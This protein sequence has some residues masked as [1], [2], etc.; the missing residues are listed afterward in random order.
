[1]VRINVYYETD[2]DTM[3]VILP[4]VK[5]TADRKNNVLA[6]SENI[7]EGVTKESRRNLCNVSLMD[8]VNLIHQ[9][10]KDYEN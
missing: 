4:N 3:T 6:Y 8:I 5:I 1:M 9:K 7:A 10:I 2:S